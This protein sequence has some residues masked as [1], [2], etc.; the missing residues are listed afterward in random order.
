MLRGSGENCLY[1]IILFKLLIANQFQM[2]TLRIN[3]LFLP[4]VLLVVS[5]N[6]CTL[7]KIESQ[8]I[9][10]SSGELNTRYLVQLFAR[11]ALNR[12]ET[13]AD[14]III[15]AGNNNDVKMEAL[16]WKVETASQL[17]KLG[18]QPQAR[19]ALT[20]TWA[21]ML[22]IRDFMASLAP[23]PVFGEW[24]TLAIQATEKNAERI[25]QIATNVLSIKEFPDYK[26]FVEEFAKQHPLQTEKEMYHEPIM[27]AYLGFK[28]ISDSTAIKTVGTLSQ[29]VA[30]A[31][32]RIGF[33]AEVVGKRLGWQTEMLLK[34][35]GLD[36]VSLETRLD[37]LE[38]ELN[39]LADV[40]ED[41]PEIL[42]EAIDNFYLKVL[43]LFQGVNS[44]VARAVQSLSRDR[45]AIDQ[46]ILRER[47]ALDTLIA[48]EREALG[49]DAREIADTG[50][51]NAFSEIHKV[52]KTVL[53]YLVLIL[54]I[55]LGL[56]FYF[57][58]LTG[59]LSG[60]RRKN[61]NE[62]TNL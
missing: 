31:T 49:R 29:V 9:P 26:A 1:G 61:K 57:G 16:K 14:S 55:V 60:K 47:M 50:V 51:K 48:R 46:M 2:K 52:I 4:L 59:R 6:S 42:A 8:E 19:V 35:Q 53:F 39:R 43:P 56:P 7:L 3:R 21:Y 40:A 24:Q 13:A 15:M 25:Q 45:Q 37:I 20:D 44:E 58:Y 30:D 32:N 5:M 12:T 36:S 18:F 41:S 17:G 38:T 34:E 62:P 23:E 22:E 28:G 54:V 27:N 10:L 11:E 33:N